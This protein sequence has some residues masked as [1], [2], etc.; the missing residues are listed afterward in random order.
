MREIVHR[1]C[2]VYFP[3]LTTVVPP[4]TV[5]FDPPEGVRRVPGRGRIFVANHSGTLD[6][7]FLLAHL[8]DFHIL[9]KEDLRKVPI[10]G[11]GLRGM[12]MVFTDRSNRF[13]AQSLYDDLCGLV[14]AGESIL[15]FPQGHRLPEWRLRDLKRGIFRIALETRA[16]VVPVA[17]VNSPYFLEPHQFWFDITE[18]VTGHVI[19][20]PAISP[21]GDPRN[22]KD[23]SMLRRQ[24]YESILESLQDH[25][26]RDHE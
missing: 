15:A 4:L 21:E 14:R 13:E 1:Y 2:R 22:P 9:G 19:A 17:I 11:W 10:F 5:R 23:V 18:P 3:I 6:I 7:V 24:V 26:G 8:Q 16:E 20:R 12:G 25:G